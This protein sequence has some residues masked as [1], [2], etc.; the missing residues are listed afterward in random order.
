ML[1][2]TGSQFS[3]HHHHFAFDC[4]GNRLRGYSSGE[5][6]KIIAVDGRSF[7]PCESSNLV[8]F[9]IIV[10][11]TKEVSRLEFFVV[12]CKEFQ[13]LFSIMGPD[14]KEVMEV[15][16]VLEEVFEVPLEVKALVDLI[17]DREVVFS[18]LLH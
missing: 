11:H 3:R 7:N 4:L 14:N 13:G 16:G 1:T 6:A 10:D 9:S 12:G 17:G 2:L 8:S 15:V 5:S 18:Q